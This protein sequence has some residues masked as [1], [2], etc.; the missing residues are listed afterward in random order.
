[1]CAQTH[2]FVAS[3]VSLLS[4]SFRARLRAQTTCKLMLY[5]RFIKHE[6]EVFECNL[7]QVFFSFSFY[8]QQTFYLILNKHLDS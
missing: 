2:Y 7:S 5:C 1:M 4:S 3:Y 8:K 6:H